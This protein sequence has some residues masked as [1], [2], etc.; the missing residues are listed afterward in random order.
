MPATNYEDTHYVNFHII[1]LHVSHRMDIFFITLF[2]GSF[3]L[4]LFVCPT[5]GQ[6]SALSSQNTGTKNNK[7]LG[8]PRTTQL[9]IKSTRKN[10]L[11][12]IQT[13]PAQ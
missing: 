5:V 8:C 10:W 1:E 11:F 6:R 12:S 4:P 3:S 13:V 9:K 7:K 2:R